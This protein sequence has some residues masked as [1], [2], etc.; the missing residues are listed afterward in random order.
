MMMM[1]G[2]IVHCRRQL[3]NHE[4]KRENR[5]D[6]RLGR[7]LKIGFETLKVI[8]KFRSS[9]QPTYDTNYPSQRRALDRP[10]TRVIFRTF[11]ATLL[12]FGFGRTG[13]HRMYVR[14]RLLHCC[15]LLF[16]LS[17]SL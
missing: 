2:V 7:N 11:F 15:F 12:F 4:K 3:I 13:Y 10:Q 16:L 17:L 1:M 9:T 5:R 8:L 14:R 6:F